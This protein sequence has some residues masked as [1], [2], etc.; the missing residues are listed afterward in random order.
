[1]DISRSF[2]TV[3][4]WIVCSFQSTASAAQ[5]MVLKHVRD[6][7]YVAEDTFFYQENSVVYVGDHH[8]TVIG[9]TWTPDTAKALAEQIQWITSKPV[10]EVIN[11]NYHPDRAGGNAYWRSIGAKIISSERTTAMM[12]KGWQEV[13]Q[14]TRKSFPTYPDLPLVLPDQILPDDFSLQQGAIQSIYLGPSHTVDGI[15]VYFPKERVLYGNC[16]LK[17][18]LGNL[19]YANLEQ[20]PLTLGK[21]K[22]LN[23]QMDTIIAGHQQPMHGPDLVDHYLALLQKRSNPR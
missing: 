11:T 14:T 18:E 22:A 4:I 17:T 2:L 13:V 10:L 5:A 21:L 6:G 20:Y 15:F 8:V 19:Q 12:K 7:V 3:A 23:L 1:M 9:A 16:I